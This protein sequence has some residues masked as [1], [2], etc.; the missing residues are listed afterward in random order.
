M[1]DHDAAAT[2]VLGA[3]KDAFD[4]VTMPAPVAQVVAAG[5]MRRRRRRLVRAGCAM[6]AIAGLACCESPMIFARARTHAH[7]EARS[8]PLAPAGVDPPAACSGS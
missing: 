2:A 4:D 6:A 5:R 7:P 3:L 8:R 1:T